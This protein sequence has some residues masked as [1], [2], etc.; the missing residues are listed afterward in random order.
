MKTKAKS[1][2]VLLL[3]CML[4]LIGCSSKQAPPEESEIL[5][6]FKEGYGSEF[7][8]EKMDNIYIEKQQTNE[9]T[10]TFFAD[11]ILEGEDEYASYTV[12]GRVTYNYYDDQGWMLEEWTPSVPE[13][14]NYVGVLNRGL[15]DEEFNDLIEQKSIY[16]SPGEADYTVVSSTIEEFSQIFQGEVRID[17]PLLSCEGELELQCDYD[18]NEWKQHLSVI[19][20]SG[21]ET[22]NEITRNIEIINIT[23]GSSMENFVGYYIKDPEKASPHYVDIQLINEE[24]IHV[25][26]GYV[27]DEN[28][29]AIRIEDTGTFDA[30]LTAVSSEPEHPEYLF[31]TFTGYDSDGQECTVGFSYNVD[32]DKI[33]VNTPNMT[34]K[35][36]LGGTLSDPDRDHEK[37]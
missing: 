11:I 20:D 4:I 12:A 33:T 16:I 21:R 14:I 8:Y 29:Y 1:L 27:P 13:D 30:V 26:T 28:G 9:E 10:K 23:T 36:I 19:P 35:S 2:I 7:I 24:T 34:D 18:G 37:Q 15:S 25:E 17:T 22:N 3:I 32:A 5:K 31:L 6:D